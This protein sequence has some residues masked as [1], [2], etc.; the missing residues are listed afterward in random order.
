MD[1]DVPKLD[2]GK[3][4]WV[5][6]RLNIVKNRGFLPMMLLAPIHFDSVSIVA[7]ELNWC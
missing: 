2:K 5:D 4:H 3:L 6:A 7:D 1:A